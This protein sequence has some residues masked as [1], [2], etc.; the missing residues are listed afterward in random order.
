MLNKDVLAHDPSEYRLA[1]GGVA[2]V[3][4]PPDPEQKTILREQLQTFVC[5]GAYADGLRRMLEGFNAAAGRRGDAP[6]AWISGFYGSGKSLLAAMLGALWT[7]FEFDD[8]A[9]AEGLVQAM[10]S[11]VKAGLRELRTNAARLGG[12]L[13]GGTTLGRGV[14]DPVKA[15]LNVILQAT[16]L[17]SGSDIRP[18]LATLWLGDEGILSD[19]RGVLGGDFIRA[20]QRFLLDNA[21]AAAALKAKPS[22]APDLDT[23][24]DRLGQQFATNRSRRWNCSSIPRARRSRSGVMKSP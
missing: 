11:E 17:P 3:L 10:P 9:T 6:A 13:V 18:A 16:G 12:L 23:L 21:F 4:F 22:L 1:D 7:N 5:E 24:M 15:V 19:V 14:H 2:K 8:G 20:S